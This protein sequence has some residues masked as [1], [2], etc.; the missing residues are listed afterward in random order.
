MTGA[1][2]N[3][4]ELAFGI[5]GPLGTD[6]SLVEKYLKQELT[7]VGYQSESL[8][9]SRLMREI[10]GEPWSSLK[11]QAR[12]EEISSH[13]RAGNELRRRL[14]KNDALALLGIGALREYREL[15]CGDPN[16][17][18]AGFASIFRSLKRPEEIE[19][20]RRIYG[21]TFFVIA[22]HAPRTRRVNDLAK[23]IADGHFKSHTN[24]YRAAAETLI[25]TD[26]AEAA[27]PF[28]QDVR[29]AFALADVIVNAGDDA[30]L[31]DQLKRFIELLFGNTLLTPSRDE[32][33]M[34]LARAAA[35][36]SA[37]L[38]R[39]VGAVICRPDGSVV[40]LGCNEV[41]CYSGGQYWPLSPGGDGRDF[42]LGQDSSDRMREN[43][44]GDILDRLKSNGWLSSD[45]TT[46]ST[47]DLVSRALREG[48]QPIMKDAQFNATIDYVRAVHAE[49]A[50]I[51]DAAR[52]G[53]PTAGCELYTTTFPCHDC[54][55]HIVAAGLNRVVY[56][57]PYPKS[58][59]GELFADSITVDSESSFT[60]TSGDQT[61]ARVRID[62]FVGIAPARYGDLFALQKRKRKTADGRVISWQPEGSSPML[63]D[64]MLPRVAR[65]TV[66]ELA[67]DEFKNDLKRMQP[68]S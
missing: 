22:A 4:P 5:V 58:L 6:T 27:N 20:L 39:Q 44:L 30:S 12:D 15:K 56:I 64:Y 37:S 53:I 16:Q 1:Q 8:R 2:Q 32:Q 48:T 57:E 50:A 7:R 42:Q 68:N 62:P 11:D 35:L 38:A 59:V 28:G 66:E 63:P 55:K 47:S 14:G 18:I 65:L 23:T 45:L 31:R 33:G 51:T 13:I 46:F 36:R 26:E 40:A 52:H 29:K 61:R 19:T 41:A 25:S 9:L 67:F 49:M 10:P 24:D 34:F 60:P 3:L 21:P 54:A 17:H 43:L